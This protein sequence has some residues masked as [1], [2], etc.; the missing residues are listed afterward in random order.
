MILLGHVP[1]EESGMKECAKWLRGFI[2]DLPIK[3][4][5]AGEN[6]SGSRKISITSNASA[7]SRRQKRRP[8]LRYLFRGSGLLKK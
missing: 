3:F 4:I 8:E 7:V 5:P 1:S 6:P 2:P